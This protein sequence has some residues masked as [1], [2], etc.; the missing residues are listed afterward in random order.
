MHQWALKM[1]K[2]PG[3]K[4]EFGSLP[5]RINDPRV[6]FEFGPIKMVVGFG[7]PQNWA[8]APGVKFE[9]G[10]LHKRTNAPE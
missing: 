8:K 7:G 9:F 3:V 5:Q 4:F 1:G 2:G 6:E 10:S